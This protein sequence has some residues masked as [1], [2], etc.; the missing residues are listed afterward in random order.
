MAASL[1]SASLLAGCA[2]RVESAASVAPPASSQALTARGVDALKAGQ[3]KEAIAAFSELVSRQPRDAAPQTLLA[4]SYQQAGASDPEALELALAGYD[5]ALKAEPGQFWAAA[6]AGRAAYDRGRFDEASRRFAQA[7]IARPDDPRALL[8]LASAT[9]MS[10]D[11]ALAAAAA[12]RAA[13]LT[14][15]PSSR[16]AALRLAALAETAAG[17]GAQARLRLASLTTQDP[18]AAAAV[19]PRVDQLQRT[20]GVD[21]V[22]T[23]PAADLPAGADQVSIDV[24]IVLSQNTSRERIGVNLLDGL[25][26]NYSNNR[27]STR[28]EGE[29][30]STLQRVITTAIGIPQLNYNLNLFNRGGQFY[31]VVARPMLTAF[32][33]ETSEFFVGRSLRVA[34]RGVNSGQLEQ[35]DIG[36]ELK[37]TPVEI[38]PGHTRIKIEAGRSFLTADPAGTFAEALTTFRQK[39]N[40][41]AEIRFGETLVLSG[42][43]ESVDDATFSKTPVIGD[44]PIVGSLFNER[45]KTSRR[46][47]VLILVTPA[48]G[49]SLPGR[50]WARPD[51]VDKLARLWTQVVDPSSNGADAAARL[52]RVRMFT[53]MAPGDA[54]LM[55]PRPRE[56]TGELL[57]QLLLPSGN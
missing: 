8:A 19:A 42:L 10:G 22:A 43:S 13:A 24:A 17:D 36:I 30:E 35:I 3:S 12:G 41:T 46:D 55:W 5:L 9:Y 21:V 53:R 34:V 2:D 56:V 38:A 32:R 37:V 33:G 11:P 23:V 18:A 52:A 1:C 20:N 51:A 48:R 44:A 40:A 6:L 28:T 31:S 27:Q 16:S 47:A 50:P 25:R 14:S 15:D 57:G 4:L 7:V 49:T 39:V 29:G 26:L 45:A 54:P